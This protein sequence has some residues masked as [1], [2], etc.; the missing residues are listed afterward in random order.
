MKFASK[1]FSYFV[2]TLEVLLLKTWNLLYVL[3]I[4]IIYKYDISSKSNLTLLTKY[5]N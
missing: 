5:K 3:I 4:L 1:V 2:I